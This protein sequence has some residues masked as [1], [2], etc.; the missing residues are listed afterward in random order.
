M[1]VKIDD[2]ASN[3]HCRVDGARG[4]VVLD[5]ARPKGGGALEGVRPL[6]DLARVYV[7][8]GANLGSHRRGEAAVES[9]ALL[10]RA[11]YRELDPAGNKG[12]DIGNV[13]KEQRK[14]I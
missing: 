10:A 8:E 5:G 1:F 14:R 3:F 2:I 12:R 7:A 11:P 13:I 9:A 6:G 4:G